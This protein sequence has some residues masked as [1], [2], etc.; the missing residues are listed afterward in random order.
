MHRYCRY[1]L[2]IGQDIDKLKT[3]VNRHDANNGFMTGKRPI[4]S[5]LGEGNSMDNFFKL[6]EKG[7]N[8]RTELIAGLTTFFTM[9]YIIFVNPSILGLTGMDKGGVFVATALAAAI[10]TLVMGLVANVPYATA[11]GMGLNAFFTFTVCFALGFAWQEALAIVF[12][13][14]IVNILITVTKIRKAIIKSI[15]ANLQ[16]A[17]AGGIGL[18]I[19]YIGFVDAKFLKYTI[20]PPNYIQLDSGTIIS[21]GA[22]VPGLVNFTDKAALLALIWPGHH[23]HPS[24]SENQR[25]HP[26]RHHSDNDNRHSDGRHAIARRRPDQFLRDRPDQGGFPGPVRIPLQRRRQQRSG[27]CHTV[28]GRRP[29]PAGHHYHHRLQSLGYFRHHR[30]LHRHRPKNRHF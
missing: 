22:V 11:P 13:C 4:Y 19:A 29:N 30:N 27:L 8:F 5:F 10:G 20:D 18:F 25:Q 28:F 14:G 15:P 6:K 1:A 24:G 21:T 12:I 26:D 17:I 7:S 9:A 23:H 2:E 16:H 3:A